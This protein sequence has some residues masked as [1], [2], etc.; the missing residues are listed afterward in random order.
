MNEYEIFKIRIVQMSFNSEL[1]LCEP[2]ELKQRKRDK[3]MISQ[4]KLLLIIKT[5]KLMHC[6]GEKQEQKEM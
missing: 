2:G 6:L 3:A 4:I 5:I 1:H